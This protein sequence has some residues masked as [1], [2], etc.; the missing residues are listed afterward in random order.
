MISVIIPVY[1]GEKY[2][3]GLID[4]FRAQG[5]DRQSLEL[6]FVDD[7]STD[8]SREI[9]ERLADEQHFT[10]S[11]YSKENGGVS[12]ARNYG[13]ERAK[14][15]Y[16]TFADVDDFVTADHFETLKNAAEENDFDVFM[17]G[18]VRVRDES[19]KV[20]KSDSSQPYEAEKISVLNRMV[21]DPTKYGVYN[22]LLK[23]SFIQKNGLKFPAG[24]KYYED[25]D[26]IYRALGSAEKILF[27]EKP[28]YYYMLREGSAMQRFV[29]DRLYCI[30][31]MDKLCDWFKTAVPEFY[32]VFSK[33]G[34]NRIYWSVLWQA[35]L[36][37]NY[38]FFK[39]FAENTAAAKRLK[40][41]CGCNNKKVALSARL[42]L[43]SKPLYYVA[44]RLAARGRSRLSS[45]NADDFKAVIQEFSKG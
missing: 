22:L 42:Y 15:E 32:P 37:F 44:A 5:A 19:K 3:N 38:S 16:I 4:N 6:V 9:L 28:L 27:T 34:A 20:P 18:S 35:A 1:N 41:L 14:G 33:W 21:N 10:L 12:E 2:I 43:V 36:A 30:S 7:G 26:F 24:F 17:F 23:K 11:V 13:I 45:A 39:Y 40:P 29:P 31:L 25:Y 8:G